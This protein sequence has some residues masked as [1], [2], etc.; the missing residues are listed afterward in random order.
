MKSIEDILRQLKIPYQ[1]APHRNVRDGWIGVDC[2]SC[3]QGRHGFY[4]GIHLASGACNCWHCGPTHLDTVLAHLANI[5]WHE[6][7]K[8]VKGLPRQQ[9]IERSSG[10]LKLPNGVKSLHRAH[11]DYLFHRGF[12]AMQLERLWGIRGI[13]FGQGLYSWSIFI[14]IH[15]HG[16]IVSWTTRSIGDN[17][18]RRYLAAPY[19][20]ES[21][22]A[23]NLLYGEDYTRHAVIVCE[24]PL[25]VWAIGPGAVAT[26]GI[27]YTQPQLAALAAF[28][29]RAVCFDAEPDAQ[30]RA[31]QLCA[32][33]S[34]MPGKTENIVL[35]TGADPAEADI[36]EIADLREKVFEA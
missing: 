18:D 10:Q 12:S 14:P 4:L 29:V 20:E 27:G 5:S 7:K 26:M 17:P 8:I 2:P 30:R 9:K 34:L 13:H 3:G 21:V 25:D 31:A 19:T 16:R 1:T 15:Q 11:K 24:G 6:A 36:D 33:L 28:P 32:T 23:K 35:E 22:R